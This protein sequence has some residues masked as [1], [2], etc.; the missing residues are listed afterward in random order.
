M[1]LDSHIGH[2]VI[3]H[4]N[5]NESHI[6]LPIPPN[7]GEVKSL[8][9][10]ILSVVTNSL[11]A[12]QSLED[13]ATEEQRSGGLYTLDTKT[14]RTD[15]YELNF[16]EE[17]F[18]CGA[19]GGTEQIILAI[20]GGVAGGVA[21]VITTKIFDL[22]TKKFS[23]GSSNSEL[24]ADNPELLTIIEDILVNRYKSKPPLYFSN[25]KYEDRCIA[26]EITDS[27]YSKYFAKVQ[28]IN[29]S[30]RIDVGRTS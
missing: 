11:G 2:V 26:L 3:T 19:S 1:K 27:N 14:F 7:D 6:V 18:Y 9:S 12:Y 24:D 5:G 10:Q 17:E 21:T 4:P 25:S 23:T 29:G 13:E 28:N 22:I 30:F 16:I 8:F 15:K 20:Y